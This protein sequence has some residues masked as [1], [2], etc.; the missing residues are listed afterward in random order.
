MKIHYRDGAR[1][2]YCAHLY[3]WHHISPVC[4]YCGHDRVEVVLKVI[5]LSV[6]YMPWTWGN[7]RLELMDKE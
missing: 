5:S 1:C 3:W 2:E 4:V 6:W 7:V